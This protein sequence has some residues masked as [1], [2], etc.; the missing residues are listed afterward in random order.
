MKGMDPDRLEMFRRRLTGRR[1]EIY[2][3]Y[4]RA[5]E[6]RRGLGEPEPEEEEAAQN[7]S[8]ADTLAEVDERERRE[9]EA[10]DEALERIKLGSYGRCEVCGKPIS[11]RRL[12]AIPWTT[13]CGE[14]A[15]TA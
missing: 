12:E 13:V 11:V 14:H 2:E 1:D 6:E 8:I 5:E 15:N 4:R 3:K 10:I 9:I 7:E